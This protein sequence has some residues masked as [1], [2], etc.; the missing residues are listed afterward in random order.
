MGA[1]PTQTQTA[2]TEKTAAHYNNKKEGGR[3]LVVKG[4]GFAALICRYQTSH[5]NPLEG[6]PAPSA[7]QPARA[8]LQVDAGGEL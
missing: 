6:T 7:C 3:Q 2:P 1:R 4:V 8:L 5:S